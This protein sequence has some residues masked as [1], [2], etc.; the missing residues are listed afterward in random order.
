MNQEIEQRLQQASTL[1]Q[2][3]ELD[4]ASAVY[5][6]LTGAVPGDPRSHFGLAMLDISRGDTAA[7]ATHLETAVSMAP[8]QPEPLRWLGRCYR[9]LNRN[10][11]A[12]AC[13]ERSGP[14]TEP[15]DL[16]ELGEALLAVGKLTEGRKAL[17]DFVDRTQQHPE[18]MLHAGM[19]AHQSDQLDDAAGFYRRALESEPGLQMARRNLAVIHQARG[20]TDEAERL[21]REVLV[22]EPGNHEVLQN[23]GTLLK[24]CDRL[25]EAIEC[26]EKAMRLYRLPCP[27]NTERILQ[28]NPG[29]RMTSLHHLKLQA[30][31]LEYLSSRG[32]LP[33]SFS[34]LAP[35]YR[36]VIDEI[37][38][39]KPQSHR[40]VL[41]ESQFA[42]IGPTCGRLMN[43]TPAGPISSGALNPQLD[44]EGIT[45]G[46]R[47]REPG[48]TVIDDFLRPDAL[49]RLRDYCIESTIWFDYRKSGGYCGSY[50]QDG[51]GSG[52]LLQ[53]AN[54]LRKRLPEIVG[55]HA[56]NQMWGYIYDSEMSGITAHADSAAVNL[57]FWITPDEANLDPESGGLVV[58]MKEAPREWDFDRYNNE[59]EAIEAF[60]KDTEAVTVPHRCNRA[61]L[62]HSNLVHKTDNIRFK[63]GMT[64]R[65]INITMLFGNRGD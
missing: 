46:Y 47:D 8:E 1:H 13:F 27:G 20:E 42:R 60:V 17:G 35:K 2:K 4:A 55:P 22:T 38:A 40:I 63:A 51:F 29:A 53:L 12:I 62:F 56:M 36:A 59:Y 32:K 19:A 23:L 16:L 24:E 26:Y 25:A 3:G 48:L 45:R 34:S 39:A 21:F 49:Q 11:D 44:F 41:N 18:A 7:A 50:M 5:R 65:R 37:D 6:S 33:P 64:N 43:L 61:V 28:Q 31:Q 58:Y 54:D 30:D 10:Q 57:N 9:A 15:G 52:L 14:A